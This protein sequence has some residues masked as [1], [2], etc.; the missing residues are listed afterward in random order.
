MSKNK[1]HC[2]ENFVYSQKGQFVHENVIVTY[3]LRATNFHAWAI[4]THIVN[5]TVWPSLYENE[6]RS[7]RS[8][9]T[10]SRRPGI[11]LTYL[12]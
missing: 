10:R 12:G 7:D 1:R 8:Y 2:H 4:N 11:G 5:S 3:K 6:Y 9:D